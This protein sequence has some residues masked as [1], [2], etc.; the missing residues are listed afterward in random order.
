[1]SITHSA[2][3]PTSLGQ[4]GPIARLE[5]TLSGKAALALSASLFI[6]LAAHVSF[7]L[8]FTPVP[9]TLG[10]MA[11]ILVGLFLPPSTAFAALILYLAE[12]AS[13]LPVFNPGGLGG[14]AQL[15]G[16]TGGFLFAYPFAALTASALVRALSRVAARFASA[17]TAAAI[18]TVTVLT[19]GFLWLAVG[20]HISPGTAFVLSVLPFLPGEIVKVLSAAGIYT[21]IR[22]WRKA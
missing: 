4:A 8:P 21:S 6:A 20:K 7:P 3:A 17:A 13:G 16:P 22:R 2:Y 5:Q 10:N 11:V 1:M 12:G 15:V 19:C 14:V 18:G 9:L